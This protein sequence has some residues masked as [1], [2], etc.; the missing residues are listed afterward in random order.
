MTTAKN[1]IVFDWNGT[2]LADTSACLNATN[3]VLHK[4][5]LPPASRAQYQHHYTMPIE[6]LYH[7][8]GVAPA[9][10][11]SHEKEIHPLWHSIYDA[12]RIRLRRGAKA[13]LTHISANTNKPIILSNYVTHRIDAQAKRL[14]VREAFG[15]IIAFQIGD[16][17]FR[18]RGKGAH[19][20]DYMQTHG[21]TSGIIIGDTEEE[22]EI[23]HELGLK[24]IALTDGMCSV[25]RLRAAK[26]D[27]L[28]RSL[29]SIPA[30]IQQVAA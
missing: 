29:S 24:S 15:E 14:G 26:P 10:L 9:L 12:A 23:G 5:G 8:L 2:I 3:S 21:I 11:D 27:Y 18:K 28:V 25:K 4:L 20:K 16:P 6:K 19:L 22:V 30:I 1:L 7:A 13:M 17:T